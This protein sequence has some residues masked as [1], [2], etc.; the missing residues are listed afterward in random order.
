MHHVV[1]L[2]KRR[3]EMSQEAFARYWIGDHTPLTAKVEGLRA[4]VCYPA[5]ADD[6]GAPFDGVAVLTFDDEAAAERAFATEAFAAALA[7]APNFQNTEL[8]TSFVAEE[9]RIV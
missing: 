2:V 1:F 9:H 7:D 5:A 3:P 8:T 4:Y 6:H